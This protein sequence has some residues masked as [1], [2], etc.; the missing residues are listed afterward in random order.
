MSGGNR[1]KVLFATVLIGAALVG[2]PHQLTG[3]PET[4]WKAGFLVFGLFNALAAVPGTWFVSTGAV[5]V[6]A[7]A[8]MMG[9]SGSWLMLL[10]VW[11][12][13]PPAYMTSWALAR[14]SRARDG[15]TAVED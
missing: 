5:L 11:L 1:V 10:L 3:S 13:W 14:E 8:L 6:S 12:I 7:A 9:T 15:T 4:W 2:T